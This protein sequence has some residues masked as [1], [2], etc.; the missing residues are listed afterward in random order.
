MKDF[1]FFPRNKRHPYGK[2]EK[3]SKRVEAA[4]KKRNE[5]LEIGLRSEIRLETNL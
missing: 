3:S 2:S 1:L 4:M 5:K